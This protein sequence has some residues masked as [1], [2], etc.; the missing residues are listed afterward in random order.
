MN[1]TPEQ[2]SASAALMAASPSGAA[3]AAGHSM[4]PTSV[5]TLNVDNE[6]DVKIES[7]VAG[8]EFDASAAEGNGSDEIAQLQCAPSIFMPFRVARTTRSDPYANHS[9]EAPF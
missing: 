8:V 5:I 9:H 7:T 3:A 2:L 1:L 4:F 6:Y